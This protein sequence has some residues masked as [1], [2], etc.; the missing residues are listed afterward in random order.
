M[1][2]T[3]FESMPEEKIR[4][5]ERRISLAEKYPIPGGAV[6]VN[7]GNWYRRDSTK[8][9]NAGEENHPSSTP[10]QFLTDPR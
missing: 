9:S 8:S 6:P 3:L 4:A 7:E 10:Q 2:N 1:T 5:A